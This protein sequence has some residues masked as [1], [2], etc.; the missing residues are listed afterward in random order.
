MVDE[1]TLMLGWWALCVDGVSCCDPGN[2]WLSGVGGDT[3]EDTAAEGC[4]I[5]VGDETVAVAAGIGA[6]VYESAVLATEGI[7]VV[8]LVTVGL[9]CI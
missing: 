6:A 9:T 1:V 8:D 5:G 3:A 4:A 7:V 2:D